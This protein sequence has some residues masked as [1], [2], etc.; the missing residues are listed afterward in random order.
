MLKCF[1]FICK[2]Y[3]RNEEYQFW[4]YG[5]QSEEIFSEKFFRSKLD[6]IHLNPVREGSVQ[7]SLEI[8]E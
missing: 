5:N 3:S 8:K 2:R 4:Q 1:E 6:D 7:K